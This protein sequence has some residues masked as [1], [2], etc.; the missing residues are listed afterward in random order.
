[1]KHVIETMKKQSNWSRMRPSR[2]ARIALVAALIGVGAGGMRAEPI[3]HDIVAADIDVQQLGEGND[4]SEVVVT[5]P[6]TIGDFR[7]RDTANRGDYDMQIGEDP[8]DDVATG[9]V[10]TS[11]RENGRDTFHSTYPGTNFATSHIES[12]D[13]GSYFIPVAM[14]WPN[15]NSTSVIEYNMNVAA[16][17]FPYS[18]WLAGYARNDV[19]G[20]G[21]AL[22][23]LVGNPALVLGTHF[24]DLG[25]GRARVDLTSLGIDSRKDGVLLV[26]GAKNEDNYALSQ[27]NQ[28]NGTWNLF[29]KDN[30]TDTTSLEQDP[31]AFVFIPKTNSAV[32]SGR[33]NGAGEILMHDGIAPRF[34]VAP[35]ETGRWELKV[36]GR[37]ALSGVL[38]ITP[39]GGGAMNLDN[40]VTY[41]VNDAGD[42][43][44][45]ES[46]DLPGVLPPLETP[47]TE[48]VASFVFVPAPTPGVTTKSDQAAQTSESGGSHAFTVEL[49]IKPAS[50]VVLALASSDE[51]EGTLSVATLTFTPENWNVPQSVTV[52]GQDDAEQDGAVAYSVTFAATSDD[53]NYGGLSIPSL[54]LSNND[55]EGGI[56]VSPVSDLATT[57]AGGTASFVVRLNTQPSGD[58]VVPITSMTPGEVSVAPAQLT[59]TTANWDQPQTV[60][61]TGADDL[62]DDG[63]RAFTVKVGPS[64]SSSA[65]YDGLSGSDVTGSN[66]DDDT[67]GVTVEP[68]TALSVMEGSTTSFSVVLNS[69]PTADVVITS[70][71]TLASEGT[72]SPAS[73]TFTPSNW[74]VPQHVTITGVDDLLGD[75][76]R[77]YKI[78]TTLASTDAVYALIDPLD[79]SVTTL[80][81][82]PHLKLGAE[83]AVFGIGSTPVGINGQATIT[84]ADGGDYDGGSLTVTITANGAAGDALAIRNTGTAAG[85]IG[86]SGSDITHGGVAV[87]SFTGGSGGSPLAVSFNA[88]ATPSVAQAVLRAV[89]FATGETG[90]SLATRALSVTLLDGDGG[91]VTET[92]SVRVAFYRVAQFQEGVDLGHGEYAGEADIRLSEASPDIAF[93]AGT[94]GDGLLIDWPDSGQPNSSQVLMRFDHIFGPGAG[95][96]PV[97]ATIVSAELLLTV[98]NPGDGGTFHRMLQEWDAT[99]ATW[100]SVGGGFYRDD[101]NARY[102]YDSAWGLVDGSGS[103]GSGTVSVGVTPDVQAWANG[104]ANF[105]WLMTGW[106]F[107]TDGT[108]IAPGEAEERSDRPRLKIV[109]LPAGASTASFRQGVDGY[110]GAKDTRLRQNAPDLD[111]STADPLFLDAADAGNTNA[112]QFLLRFEDITGA[113][114]GQVPAGARVVAAFLDL[115]SVTG[116]A[117][118]H[119]GPFHTMKKAW[120]DTDTWNSLADGLQADGVEASTTANL[121]TGPESLVPQVQGGFNTFDVTTDVQAWVSGTQPNYGWGAIPWELGRN[122][123]GV[124][125]SEALE[126][127]DRPRLRVYY[128]LAAVPE[129]PISL[130]AIT[131]KGASYELQINAAASTTFSVERAQAIT[132]PWSPAGSVTT[133]ATGKAT[134]TD[135]TPL[136]EA[137][138]YRLVKP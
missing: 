35:I 65:G 81:N 134:H 16:A 74:N 131:R 23:L 86:V 42:G 9:I 54:P 123:W 122:G 103:S 28:T 91:S 18:T 94:A 104:S 4:A 121:I 132:G 105:G 111:L 48:P 97:G 88:S 120:N 92:G 115:A 33:F 90:A 25:G 37:P 98:K 137:G 67:A 119:G 126:E 24:V 84:D 50:D 7:I 32:V 130:S 36:T 39:E 138:F 73:I 59:F 12:Q 80:D 107:N 58:V 10:I 5:T 79:V 70:A 22:N 109:W 85:Q 72:V 68:I 57:E 13:A 64:T 78:E 56:T 34:T 99:N 29:S 110:A 40:I 66:A 2:T 113:G 95:Q 19:R 43:W 51:T 116:D 49:D 61:L 60:T 133:D 20:N 26:L 77:S 136:P 62:V 117:M 128:S 11:I 112:S 71:S 106:E 114:S 83:V 15:A 27:V 96:I 129:P 6:R 127:R 8:F 53:P 31:F 93:P 76:D 63:A 1:M 124:S 47:G 46:R 108:G 135:E 118:G 3:H 41:Q 14:T 38:I 89:T 44:I 82:E 87:G 30:G 100:N 17:F 52:T 125:S 101:Y 102:D 75:G 69:Q 55:N 45:I 21:A